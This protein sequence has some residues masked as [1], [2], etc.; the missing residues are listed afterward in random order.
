MSKIKNGGLDQYGAEPF[1]QQ[2]FGTAGVEGVNY[3][4]TVLRENM[5]VYLMQCVI[6]GAFYGAQALR[7][8]IDLD[9]KTQ[10]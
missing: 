9:N 7:I 5:I 1:E 10:I 3:C 8:T 2:Q 4:Y 6:N